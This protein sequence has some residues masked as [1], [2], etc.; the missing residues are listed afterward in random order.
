[1]DAILS[2][3]DFNRGWGFAKSDAEWADDFI[4]EGQAPSVVRPALTGV[5]EDNTMKDVIL[6]HTWNAEDM[7]PGGGLDE[8]TITV[9]AKAGIAP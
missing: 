1:M 5:A 4:A 9:K 8:G 3:I 7:L 6:P 2:R